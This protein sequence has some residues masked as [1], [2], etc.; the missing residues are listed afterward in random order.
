M[1]L[2]CISMGDIS[3]D[4]ASVKELENPVLS[5]FI[6]MFFQSLGNIAGGMLL[7]KFAN[8]SDWL[9]FKTEKAICSP[10]TFT[11]VMGV[12]NGIVAILLHFFWKERGTYA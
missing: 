6:Q 8:P 1:I 3:L 9:L 2:L 7:M 10:E 4:A 5:S 11:L 12:T